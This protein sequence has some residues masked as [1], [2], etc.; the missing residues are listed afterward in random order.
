MVHPVHPGSDNDL[1]QYLVIFFRNIV[2][3]VMKE[4]DRQHNCFIEEQVVGGYA[5]SQKHTP[6]QYSGGENFTGMEAERGGGIHGRVA[7]VH[8]VES[9]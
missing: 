8:A 3:A 9:P 2:V 7:V 1:A 4:N 5:D 6:A